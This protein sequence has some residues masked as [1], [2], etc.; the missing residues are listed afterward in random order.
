MSVLHN[1]LVFETERP[2]VADI[3][4]I[5]LLTALDHAVGKVLHTLLDDLSVALS[6]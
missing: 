5:G 1:A 6:H 2:S 4:N 3:F